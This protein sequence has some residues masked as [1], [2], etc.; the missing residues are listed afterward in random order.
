M[1][2]LL[3]MIAEDNL[4]YAYGLKSVLENNEQFKVTGIAQNGKVLLEMLSEAPAD[5]VMMD[6]QMPEMDGI[7]ATQKIT[8][9]YPAIKVIALTMLTAPQQ[10]LAIMQ[11]GA[12]GYLSKDSTAESIMA[13]IY[14]VQQGN[15]TYCS[16]TTNRIA[17]L[18]AHSGLQLC[19]P[20]QQFDE[21]ERKIIQLICKDH[22]NV[23]IEAMLFLTA[24]TYHRYLKNIWLKMNVKGKAGLVIY[25]YR[26][27]LD[28]ELSS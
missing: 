12:R 24:S 25:A 19:S 23:A 9:A 28:K 26:Y 7:E 16:S 2:P 17:H 21:T 6:I 1:E 27:G 4:A 10:L 20:L 18:L 3:L 11:A 14:E 5:I 8:A 22:E 15:Y 13:A